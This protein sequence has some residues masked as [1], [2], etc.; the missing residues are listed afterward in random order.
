MG[1]PPRT[2]FGDLTGLPDDRMET[3]QAG[4]AD[5]G[6]GW[7]IVRATGRRLRAGVLHLPSLAE[8]RAA[9]GD[10]GGTRPLPMADLRGDVLDLH[11]D[12]ALAGAVFQVASQ[13]NLLE[14]VGPEVTPEAGMAGY[15]ADRTQG[16][17]C[18]MA[19]GAGRCGATI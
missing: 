19:C 8:L 14:M 16:P 13:F 6:D 5:P 12:P 2:W 11:C 7:L 10:F 18:A 1:W 17:A 9:T 3:V 4:I 15:W